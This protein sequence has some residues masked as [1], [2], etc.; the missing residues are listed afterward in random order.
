MLQHTPETTNETLAQFPKAIDL[1]PNFAMAYWA[2]GD[3]YGESGE[4]NSGKP[5][6]RKAFE[7][8]GPISQREKWLTNN[9]D[10]RHCGG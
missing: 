8:R 9:L 4:T 6:V 2:I 7:L 3:A 1:D 10:I 5:Y